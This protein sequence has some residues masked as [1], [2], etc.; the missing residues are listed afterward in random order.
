MRR[1]GLAVATVAVL[2]VT[3]LASP[4]Q[5]QAQATRPEG[6]CDYNSGYDATFTDTGIGRTSE[7]TGLPGRYALPD[8]A[9]VE[10]TV[11]I[12][13][14]HGYGNDSCS[15]RRH[16]QRFAG[17]GALAFAMDYE[18]YAGAPANHGRRG[19]S[20]Q[21]GALDSIA[22]ATYFL[23]HYPS[24]RTVISF[25]ISMGGNA[26]G[27]AVAQQAKRADGSPL[28]DYWIGVE[29]VSNLTEEYEALAP[30]G[31]VNAGAEEFR[32]DVERETGGTLQAAPEA[33]RQRTVV[34]RA[35]DIAAGGL[36]GAVL[37]HGID[38]G[39]V[40]NNQVHEMTGA[41]RGVGV[42]VEVY[43]V[44]RSRTAEDYPDDT[45][46]AIALAALVEGYN[47]PLA[48]HGWEG[49]NTQNVIKTGFDQLLA[50]VCGSRTGVAVFEEHTIDGDVASPPGCTA[51]LRATSA[52]AGPQAA[53]RDDGP[54]GRRPA[55]TLPATGG[56]AGGAPALLASIAVGALLVSRRVRRAA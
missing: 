56:G 52:S 23:A 54:T 7:L 12:A 34:A 31:N 53:A 5:A 2:V 50:L 35:P 39:L 21:R 9:A 10:P 49:S 13:M 55:G 40:P 29:G 19:W 14:F 33:F 38:D 43:N 41:L 20:V 11:L 4:A 6:A 48:G 44:V 28:F 30:L 24:I 42:P 45:A 37:V 1:W 26:S 22:Q 16:L 15:W 47:S 8:P 3:A 46:S 27:L 25:G 18:P 32:I 51:Q 17:T 36:K